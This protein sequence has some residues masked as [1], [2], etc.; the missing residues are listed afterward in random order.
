M[1]MIPT[2]RMPTSPGEMPLEEFIK[3]LGLTQRALAEKLGMSRVAVNE[4]VNSRRSIT[5]GTTL[6]KWRQQHTRAILNEQAGDAHVRDRQ[7]DLAHQREL[8]IAGA[9]AAPAIGG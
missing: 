2:Y 3:P 1:R 6:R 7:P 4:I 5:P 8:A 9:P